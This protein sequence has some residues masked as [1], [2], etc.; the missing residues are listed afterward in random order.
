MIKFKTL[1][2]VT[3]ITLIVLVVSII[4]AASNYTLIHGV[5]KEYAMDER[6]KDIES[7]FTQV[8]DNFTSES[9]LWND[10]IISFLGV[11]ALNGGYFIRLVDQNNRVVFDIREYDT[12]HCYMMED[13]ME[14]N[15]EKIEPNF[16]GNYIEEIN[17]ILID[18]RVVGILTVGYYGDYY[19]DETDLDFLKQLNQVLILVSVLALAIATNG[20]R[21]LARKILVSITSVIEATTDISNGNYEKRI[22]TKSATKEVTD[23][24]E[25][26]NKMA[27][28]ID[29]SEKMKKQITLDVAHEL[30]TPITTISTHLEAMIDGIW[31]VSKE[32]LQSVYEE[33]ERLNRLVDDLKIVSEFDGNK[34]SCKKTAFEIKDF[35]NKIY[36]QFETSFSKSGIHF[37]LENNARGLV[38]TDEDKLMQIHMNLLQNAQRYTSI[39][40]KVIFSSEIEEG[41]LKI[42]VIDNGIGIDK[43][44]LPYIF[45]R[46]YRVDKSRNSKTGGSGIGLTITKSLVVLCG[47][48][49]EVESKKG[50]GTTF[51]VTIPVL[52]GVD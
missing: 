1:I 3:F 52:G 13:I 42:M 21:I 25:S 37:I 50:I 26:V 29:A 4:A 10:T 17:E 16:G 14:T 43:E 11:S 22:M 49:I 46:F 5:F 44:E 6:K 24:I 45:D 41:F 23:L 15:M 20:A 38:Y 18:N 47:G 12:M 32:R 36:L 27:V 34:N 7:I 19:Y 9:D 39:G 2:T 33:V 28:S 40:G 51:V 31:D 30:R 35:N 48:N 8:R